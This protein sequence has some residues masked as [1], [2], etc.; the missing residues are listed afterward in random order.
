M[1]KPV[2]K[3]HIRHRFSILLDH[4]IT[5]AKLEQYALIEGG[6]PPRTFQRD[7]DI[8]IND[9]QDIPTERLVTYAK[10]LKCK[11]HQLINYKSNA[12]PLSL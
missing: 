9:A 8:E 12:K 11:V 1:D 2:Y 4:D 6:I 10:I 3:Y 7:R 5:W